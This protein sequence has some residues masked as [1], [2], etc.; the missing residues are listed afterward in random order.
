MKGGWGG[1]KK[2]RNRER[3]GEKDGIMRLMLALVSLASRVKFNT[4]AMGVFVEVCTF[5]CV[6]LCACVCVH[7]QVTK[8][9][10]WVCG[11]V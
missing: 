3:E 4:A 9:N 1:G 6:C 8:H 10:F 2:E 7:V 11:E 5:V